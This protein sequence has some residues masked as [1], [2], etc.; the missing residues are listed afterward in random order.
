M[1]FEVL[2]LVFKQIK[3]IYLHR[4]LYK[5]CAFPEYTGKYRSSSSADRHIKS[6]DELFNEIIYL[7]INVIGA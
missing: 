2:V 3:I 1:D 6:V 7:E 4:N 5:R